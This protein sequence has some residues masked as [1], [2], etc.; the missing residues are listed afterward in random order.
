VRSWSALREQM[1]VQG[2]DGARVAA[3]EGREPLVWSWETHECRGPA[4][5]LLLG[6]MGL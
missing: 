4:E 6:T 5:C 1:A 2:R 3:M